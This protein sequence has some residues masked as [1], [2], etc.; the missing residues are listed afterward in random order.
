MADSYCETWVDVVGYEG[1]YQVSNLGNLKSIDRDEIHKNG[2]RRHKKGQLLKHTVTT[3]GRHNVGLHRDGDVTILPVDRIVA[4]AFLDEPDEC[5]VLVHV[6]G[7][8]NDNRL[9]NLRWI[10]HAEIMQENQG[11]SSVEEWKDIRGYEGYYQVSNRGNVRSL[12]R[13][14]TTSRCKTRIAR[15]RQMRL[16]TAKTGYH[17]VSLMK[18]G[19]AKDFLVHRLVAECFIENADNLPQ[20]DHINSVRDDN[21]VENLRWVSAKENVRNR[22]AYSKYRLHGQIARPDKNENK[23]IDCSLEGEIWKPVVG[24]EGLY[25]VSSL[26]R[27]RSTPRE[28]VNSAGVRTSK[29]GVIRYTRPNAHGYMS[30]TLFMDG[31]K[32]THEVHRL[33]AEAFIEKPDSKCEVDHIDADR[34]NNSVE[35]L[36]WVDHTENMRNVMRHGHMDIKAIIR[37]THSEEANRNR[38][39]ALAKPVMRDDGKSYESIVDAAI[40]LGYKTASMVSMHLRGKIDKC[41][42][43]T[44]SYI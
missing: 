19:V 7:D 2:V 39:R 5:S 36:R 8:N 16:K 23:E 30:V 14:V 34:T 4:D 20:V 24:Y 15:G 32:T 3:S 42:G 29:P 13:A 6:N 26:G 41:R 38:K 18:N 1:Y 22:D 40:D 10:P 25:E 37:R 43:H 11:Y 27:V 33:V 44:F 31:K 12:D 21:R 9:E 35:N 17:T 28:F